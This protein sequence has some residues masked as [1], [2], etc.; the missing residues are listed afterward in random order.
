MTPAGEVDRRISLPVEKPTMPAFGGPDL[1]T[2][3]I[4]T[5][6]GGGS[7]P[8]DPAQPEAGGLFAVESGVRGLP[9]PHS[10]RSGGGAAR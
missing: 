10:G 9:E 6:G 7:H 8:V 2:L 3:F 1:S 4:T 5:I